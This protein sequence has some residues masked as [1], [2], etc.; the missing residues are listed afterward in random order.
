[1][2]ALR[3]PVYYDF[4]STL[5]YVAHRVMQAMAHD[6]EALAVDLEW[7]PVDL[8]RITGWRRHAPIDG[9]RRENALRAA[10]ELGVPVRMPVRWPDS[11]GAHVVALGL[12]SDAK[13]AAWRERVW[14]AVHEEGRPIDEPQ[15][16]TAIAADLDIDAP[17]LVTRAALGRLAAETR[18]AQGTGVTGV[19]TFQLGTFPMA[20]IQEPA[21]MRATFERFARRRRAGELP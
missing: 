4:A 2:P 7:R 15:E 5:C 21:T 19:P 8:S 6:L 12:P 20:G 11:R 17:A 9:P 13:R 16:L 10:Q 18:A 3:I 14:S 1:V